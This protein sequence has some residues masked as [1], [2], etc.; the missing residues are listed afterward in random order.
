MHNGH[1]CNSDVCTI[2]FNQRIPFYR[3]ISYKDYQRKNQTKESYL[4]QILNF[5]IMQIYKYLA[6]SHS[7]ENDKRF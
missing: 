4:D 3:K 5:N 2:I 6:K 7:H 1:V